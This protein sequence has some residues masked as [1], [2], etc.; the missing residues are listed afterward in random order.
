MLLW[1][2]EI[3]MYP[4]NERKCIYSC[5][6]CSWILA[7]CPLHVL[8]L[9]DDMSVVSICTQD[10][11][12]SVFWL[13]F[14]FTA[15]V[16]ISNV[17]SDFFP[18]SDQTVRSTES[19]KTS[20][21]DQVIGFGEVCSYVWKTVVHL[22]VR[23]SE[24]IIR[25]KNIKHGSDTSCKPWWCCGCWVKRPVTCSKGDMTIVIDLPIGKYKE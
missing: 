21:S 12:I 10:L 3:R 18:C 5:K 24:I 15:V 22:T 11:L 2:R 4:K 20:T 17:E 6:L 1:N 19:S 8:V 14:R 23:S 9:I 16:F 13:C 7:S 25:K